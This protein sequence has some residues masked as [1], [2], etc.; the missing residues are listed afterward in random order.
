VLDSF[1]KQ[2]TLC[3]FIATDQLPKSIISPQYLDNYQNPLPL[4]LQNSIKTRAMKKLFA[5]IAV[6]TVFVAC[7]NATEKA[8]EAVDATK[9]TVEAAANT[10]DSAA[11]AI[12][13]SAAAKLN[14]VADTAKAKVGAVVDSLKK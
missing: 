11:N 6:A 12:K 7:N 9:S 13:D 5:I 8:S 4:Q 2:T 3:S 14:Q 1:E 10:V